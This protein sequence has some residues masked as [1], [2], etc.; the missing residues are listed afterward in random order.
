[1]ID[2]RRAIFL[3]NLVQ[4]VNV[5]RPLVFMAARDFGLRVTILASAKFGLRDLFGIWQAELDVLRKQTGADLLYYKSDWQAFQQLTGT[6]L[7]FAASESGLRE[8]EATHA[9]FRFAPPTFLRVTLQH[10]FECVGFRH[11]AAHDLAYGARVSS[12]ADLLCAWQP[13]EFQ[14][15]M[16]ASQHSKVQVTGPTSLL[17]AFTEPVERDAAAPGMVCENLH[18]VRLKA[19]GDPKQEFMDVFASF[20][21]MLG[22]KP[23]VLRPHPGGQYMIK[24]ALEVA[25]NVQVNNAPMYRLDLRRLSYGISAPSSVL[26]DM[27]LAGIPTA[28][29]RDREGEVDTHNYAGLT[30]V[31]GPSEWLDFAREASA[32]PQQFTDRQRRFLEAQKIP[33]QPREVFQRYARIFAAANRLRVT[34]RV[35]PVERQRLLFVAN[36]RLPSLQVCLERPLAA[37]AHSG[38][39]DTELLTEERLKPRGSSSESHQRSAWLHRSLDAFSPDAIIFSRYS[40]PCVAEMLDW[41]RSNR[42]PTIFQIDDDLLGVPESLGKAKHAYH[43]APQRLAAVR[44]LLEGCDLVYAS[45]QQLRERLLEHCPEAEIVAGAINCSGRV[46][47]PPRHGPARL[48]GYMA[49]VD[50]LPNLEMVLPAIGRLL[51]TRP[52][53][54]FELFGSIPVPAQLER[55]GERIRTF[56]PEPNYDDF[57]KA[58]GKREWDVGI[59]PLT[60]TAFNRTK[61]NNKWVEYTSLGIASVASG[62]MVYDEACA[63]GCGILAF[64]V[65]DW[66]AGLE[67]LVDDDSERLAMVERAQRKLETTYAIDQHRQQILDIIERARAFVRRKATSS[68]ALAMGKA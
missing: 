25:P 11:S 66:L 55:F 12:G 37:L 5:L 65:D 48:I 64:D 10:G 8:H 27:L 59:C 26:L 44:A 18:S 7:I 31:S 50:H 36:A 14:S 35:R 67:R 68:S 16:P 40:G 9:L 22:D 57:L 6:G 21:E 2:Q 23:V 43:N 56:P 58:L 15:S 3:M 28:V 42:V 1:M 49:S 60:P 34:N 46:L 53:L 38:D 47:Q 41:A 45:T 17:Q 4:D 33:L 52:G 13:V 29:W 62:G 30:E 24:N 63:D 54:S 19:P 32:H 51:E 61:S 20:C 39:L